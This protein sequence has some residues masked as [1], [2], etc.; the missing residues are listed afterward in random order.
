MDELAI[1]F[2]HYG[3]LNIAAQDHFQRLIRMHPR[4]LV[5]PIAYQMNHSA[6]PGTVDVASLESDY[7]WPI[8][9]P[10]SEC[11]K[12]YYRWFLNPKRPSARRYIFFEY[13]IL[14]NCTAQNFYREV[15]NS[16]V[17]AADIVDLKTEP[18]WWAAR[19]HGDTHDGL[20][21]VGMGLRPLAGIFWSH[22]ALNRVAQAT[23]MPN[24][25]CEFHAGTLA[26]HLGFQP[27]VILGAIRAMHWPPT[28]L[29]DTSAARWF[30]PV[31]DVHA[32]PNRFRQRLRTT[33]S[34][35]P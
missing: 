18:D 23:R 27:V 19:W 7:G 26:N 15:W 5:I 2:L 13:D 22:A 24:A 16:D 20:L 8:V 4:D 30:H 29:R 3:P 32:R 21:N 35:S 33:I 6:I 14:P 28:T 12:I 10:Y 1:L 25:W 9:D 17:A 31:K 34:I 11:D